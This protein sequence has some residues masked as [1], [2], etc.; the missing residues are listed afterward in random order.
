MPQLPQMPMRQDQRNDR[1]VSISF[2][3]WL[4]PSRTVHSFRR[5]TSYSCQCG[6]ESV[7]GR[8]RDT[9]SPMLS[10]MAS[11]TDPSP[12]D[13]V[14]SHRSLTHGRGHLPQIPHPRTWSSPVDPLARGPAGDGHREALD[15]R[16]PVGIAVHQQVG[17]ELVVVAGGEI[18]ALVRPPG[19]LPLHAGLEDALADVEHVGQLQGG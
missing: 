14:I 6:S 2:L 16:R 19:L 12:T 13:V 7:S 15:S 8:Y 17:Q 11:P 18:G 9:L 3:T 5:G 1:V 10:A 4:R